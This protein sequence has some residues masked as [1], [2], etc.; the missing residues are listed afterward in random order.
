MLHFGSVSELR[1][2]DFF[3]INGELSSGCL[4]HGSDRVTVQVRVR[5]ADLREVSD[6][7]LK[8]KITEKFEVDE[9]EEVD[10]KFSEG[11][12][13]FIVYVKRQSLV[14][15]VRS[16]PSNWHS[17]Y[18]DTV[19]N[20]LDGEESFGEVLSDSAVKHEVS[21]Q[22]PALLNILLVDLQSLVLR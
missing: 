7:V 14:E 11:A 4:L 19:V 2:H 16:Y 21:V 20:S 22:F 5:L 6:R 17:H 9:L 12:H 3:L 1:V 13:N 18:F 15:L 10:V 8:A